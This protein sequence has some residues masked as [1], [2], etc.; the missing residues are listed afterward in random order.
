MATYSLETFQRIYDDQHG[1]YIQIG[2]DP[3]G[4]GMVAI[5][6]YERDGKLEAYMVFTPEQ[7]SLLTQALAK[8]TSELEKG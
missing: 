8:V 5:R 3:D 4:L 7:V 2:P 1:S 6:S